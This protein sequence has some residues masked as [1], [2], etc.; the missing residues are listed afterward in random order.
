VGRGESVREIKCVRVLGGRTIKENVFGGKGF[1]SS[2]TDCRRRGNTGMEKDG[3]GEGTRNIPYLGGR[4]SF[5]KRTNLRFE[6][7]LL[8][9]TETRARFLHFGEKKTRGSLKGWGSGYIGFR[10]RIF[11]LNARKRS[12]FTSEF[13]K[14]LQEGNLYARW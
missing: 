7:A 8:R 4:T 3:K 9:Q 5:C 10:G 2:S 14:P 11:V 6:T 1:G 13:L 12:G